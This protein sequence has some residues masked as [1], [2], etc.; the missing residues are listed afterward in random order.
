MSP[1]SGVIPDN[2]HDY[3]VYPLEGV[4]D[5]HEKAKQ[6]YAGKIDKRLLVY[7]LMIRQPELKRKSQTHREIYLS[8]ARKTSPERYRTV[9]RFQLELL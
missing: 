8:N 2:Y 6:N 7:Q 4:W 1:K 9:L 3:A 5:I